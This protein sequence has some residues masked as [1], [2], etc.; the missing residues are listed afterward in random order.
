MNNDDKKMSS[1]LNGG[2]LAKPVAKDIAEDDADWVYTPPPDNQ[3]EFEF[4]EDGLIFSSRFDSGNLI[5]VERVGAYRYNM[6]TSPDCGNSPKQTNNRQWFHFAIRG[7][8]R[9]C[10]ITFTF[11]GM[12]HSKMFTY[13]WMPVVAVCPGRP[14]YTRLPGRA[15]VVTLDAMPPTPGYPA[16]VMK[17]WV[18]KSSDVQGAGDAGNED[19]DANGSS[20][21]LPDVIEVPAAATK[22][23][24]KDSSVAMNLTFE[25]RLDIDTSLSASSYSLGHPQCPA[26]YVASNHP[27]SYTTLQQNIKAW[28]QQVAGTGKNGIS[29]E[30]SSEGGSGAYPLSTYFHH[31]ILCK[32][33]DGRNVD[34]LTITD[35]SGI[36]T[37]RAPL[38]AE[39]D[40]PYSSAMG[41]TVRP[42]H[43]V[44]KQFVVLSAR[45][46]PGESPSSHVMHGCIEFLLSQVDPRAIALRSR[47][48]FLLVPMI[49]PDGVVRGHSRA[50]TEGV[51][52]NRKYRNP[53]KRRH[54][55]PYCIR[56]LLHSIASVR[57]RLALFI[58]M[59]AHANKR[60]MFFYGNSMDA[61]ELLQSLMYTKLVALNTPYFEFQSSNF[62][63][64]NMFATGKTGEGRDNSSRVTL[65]QETGIVHSYTIEVSYVIGNTL[66][67]LP[68][69][70][71]YPVDEPEVLQGT[72]CPKY[73]QSAFADVGKALLVALLDMKGFNP[74]SRLP[75]TQYHTAKGLLAALQRQLQVE[76]AERL[77]KIA[78][79]NGGQ[80]ALSRETGTDPLYVVMAALRREDLPD[81]M[82]IKDGRGIPPITIRGFSDFMPLDQAVQLLAHT[83]PTCPPRTFVCGSGRRAMSQNAGGGPSGRRSLSNAVPG[84]LV[85]GSATGAVSTAGRK[86]LTGVN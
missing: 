15:T 25:V 22:K 67:S 61:P 3:R 74:M 39:G 56:S 26:T 12:M 48:V 79:M 30:T 68:A 17:P 7:G 2:E 69:I 82:T 54:P 19:A 62:S 58:D 38:Y 80:A 75:V 86:P 64:A 23:K 60:G 41:E 49:N 14:Q 46:H 21:G 29:P 59:H 51:N 81:L 33:L 63:E 65:Y 50:D 27:Y 37:D 36:C 5:Q 28:K 20:E 47:F 52:L 71:N 18:K 55:A 53:S 35:R 45:V 44:G 84:M 83:P 57:G 6:Y 9:G 31:E 73:S 8:S 76:S 40:I 10:V 77:F 85:V 1:C 16:F 70:S 72:P 11:V 43:F 78:F 32:S 24:K 13:G 34:L 4:P 66:N 42:H